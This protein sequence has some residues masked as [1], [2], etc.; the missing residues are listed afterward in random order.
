MIGIISDTHV[1]IPAIEDA[2]KLFNSRKVKLVLHAGDM[3]SPFTSRPFSKLKVPMKCVYGNNDGD[4][5]ALAMAYKGIGDF[6]VGEREVE[7]AGKK[8]LM[9]HDE[10]PDY[11][12]DIDIAIFGHTHKAL[13]RRE[14]S[15]LFINPGEAGGWVTGKRT[16]AL[17]KIKNMEAEI[18]EF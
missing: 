2:V 3:V 11:K 5:K 16:L 15:R 13:I 8:I 9:S 6:V 17:L 4:Y 18:I 12:C 7:Y 1:N 14:D 10:L